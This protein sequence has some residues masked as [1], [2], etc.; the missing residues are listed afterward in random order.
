MELHSILSSNNLVGTLPEALAQIK[1]L[2]D[3]RITD[4]SGPE[5]PLLNVPE[6]MDHL[7]LRNINLN[8]T[9]PEEAW[10]GK[11]VK[12]DFNIKEA[13]N[14]S[15]TDITIPFNTT[16][17]N[18]TLEI[19]LYWA[20]RG[21]TLIPRRGDYGPIISAISVCSVIGSSATDTNTPENELKGLDLK[22]GSFTLRQLKAATENFNSANKIGEGGFGSVYKGELADGTIIAV[23]QLS[24]K[25]RQGNREFVNEIGMI[26]CLQ[27]PNLVNLYGCCIEGDQLLLVYE[28]MENNSLARALFGSE[29]SALMLDWPTRYKICVGIARG[30]AFLHEGSAIRIVH[31]D[32]KGTNV[33]LDKD[34][35]AKI[36]DFG[37]AKLNEEE[38]THIARVAGTI[39]LTFNKLVGELPRSNWGFSSTGDFMDDNNFNDDKYTLRSNS[40]ISPVVSELYKTARRT[41]LSIT[42]YGY[43]LENGDYTVRLHFAEIQ[44]TNETLRYEVARRVFDIYIQGKRVKQD[45]NIKEAAKGS[46]RD[47]TIPFNTTVINSTLE[48]RLYWAGKG[49]T[50]IPRRGDYGPII[51]AIS[52]CSEPEEASKK[53][54]VIGVVTSAVFLIFLGMGVSYWK[55]C[56]G[57]K[58]TRERD[59]EKNHR[60][61]FQEQRKPRGS[62]LA[63][64]NK[65]SSDE[66]PRM[67][68]LSAIRAATDNFSV[69]NK[70]G[71]GGFGPVYKGILSDGSEV[72][73][74]RLSRSSE[75]GVQELKNEV[76]TKILSG[77]LVFVLKERKSSS[78]MN[79]CLTAALM[80]IDIING[81]AKG[82][83]YLHE[84]SRLKI[85]HRDLK[86]SNILLD[87]EMNPKISDFGMAR[88]FS[89]H[90][91]EANT[92]RIVGTGYMAPEYAMEGLYSTKSDVF[93][94]GVLLLEIISGRKKAGYHLP[95]C[96]PSLLACAWQLWNEGNKAE[97]IDPML[98][99][100]CNA[101]EFSRY[102]HIGLLCVQEDASDRPTMSSVVL[103]LKSH[104]SFLPQPER[105]AFV[106]RFMD[107][108]KATA[109]NF[110]VNEMTI[111]DLRLGNDNVRSPREIFSRR[112]DIIN[113]I[114]KGMLYLHEDSRLKIVHRDLKASNILLDN[115]MNP[116]ISDFGMARIFSSHE[117]EANTARIDIWHQ[118]MHFGVT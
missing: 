44:Y 107:N 36:S 115:E 10:S 45:F 57:H 88:I 47:I 43:C 69:S 80:R 100:S 71:Q 20:G 67:M 29:T 87:N 98:S 41:P 109:S 103:M 99:D 21:S 13:A 40:D 50:V 34:L 63:E 38:N 96:A 14:G 81:I 82:M 52:V 9:I 85:V 65:G 6:K 61:F 51:S 28:Y 12:Q 89:S 101:E 111:S 56:Y 33:L 78:S 102:M 30:L 46:N 74:K 16:V 84:D 112:I 3:L 59:E 17:I 76:R 108:L 77:C 66:L 54:I 110:S 27:H 15:N 91:D 23:K 48:I 49:S 5:F 62:T 70:L 64:G 90:E 11:R 106:G 60:S 39:D 35:N 105:P 83:L 4:T 32:I 68:D 7:V 42:Y 24:S 72:A 95:R 86:A 37:L 22:T 118:N 2:T 104:N 19:R 114:A 31:R 113:G 53:P 92:A 79:S 116:K 25:S 1:N 8:G 26:S 97:L 117:D 94:F 73:V 93:S 55:F 75:Q 58:H 18:S